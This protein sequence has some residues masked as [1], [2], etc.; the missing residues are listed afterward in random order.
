M[1]TRAST[2]AIEV[3]GLRKRYAS[4]REALRGVDLRVD[5]GEV[6]AFLG[7]NGAGKTTFVEIVEGFRPRSGG[8]VSVLGTDPAAAGASWRAR[9]GV[10]AQTPALE[11]ELTVGECVAFHADLYPDPMP[12]ADALVLVGLTDE[13]RV[14]C[15]RLSGGQRRRVELAL[16]LIG[17]PEVLFLDEPTTG[18][19]PASRRTAWEVLRG[20]GR[21]GTTVF[22][23]TH[24]LE[25][26]EALA[27]RIA[28]IVDG[29]IVAEGTPATLGGRDREPARVAFRYEHGDLDLPV[30]PA[31]VHRHRQGH[32][33]VLASVDPL[34]TLHAL[35]AWTEAAGAAVTGLSVAQPTLEDV[36]LRL[37]GE[38]P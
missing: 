29:R 35:S 31:E 16:A 3:N 15:G 23:T 33:V 24:H 14:R 6:F 12:V 11:P 27:D 26:A 2:P 38:H 7:P 4:G 13:E 18:F 9:V 1:T 28:V 8:R 19:D 32:D 36:Y 5:Q 37:I 22:V 30:L 21:I 10:V 20:R 25:E 34:P 17:R